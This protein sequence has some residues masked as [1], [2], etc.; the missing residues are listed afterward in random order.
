MGK[1]RG[2]RLK[3]RLDL[4]D[5]G[6]Q[7]LLQ[8]TYSQIAAIKAQTHQSINRPSESPPS[9]APAAPGPVDSAPAKDV[10]SKIKRRAIARMLRIELEATLE[11]LD[12]AL[13]CV[14]TPTP[15]STAGSPG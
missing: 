15:G 7:K 10:I 12:A 6:Q 9:T 3:K 4:G 5:Q 13:A 14:S 11:V 1:Q 2:I 8:V